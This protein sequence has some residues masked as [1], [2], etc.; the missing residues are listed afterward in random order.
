MGIFI[1]FLPIILLFG[2]ASKWDIQNYKFQEKIFVLKCDDISYILKTNGVNFSLFNSMFIPVVSKSL[3]NGSFKS[4]KFLPPNSKFDP[5]FIEI[6]KMKEKNLK[7]A[8]IKTKNLAC[9]VDEI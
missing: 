3:E 8:T 7:S 2:C 6:L 9:E 1:R 4:D 5:I